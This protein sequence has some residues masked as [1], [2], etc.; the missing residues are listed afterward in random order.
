MKSKYL[1]SQP[2]ILG[3]D[4]SCDET[5]ASIVKG[6]RVLSNV[7]SSQVELHRKYGGVVPSIAKREHEERLE[8]VILEALSNAS[9]VLKNKISLKDIDAVAVTYG[10][11][12]AIALET[13]IRKAKEISKEYDKPLIAVN[14]MEGHLLSSLAENSK[15]KG[16]ISLSKIKFP[17]LGFLLSGGHTELILINDIGSYKVI[18]QTVDDAVGEAYD[19]V[20]RM[21]GLGYP[22]GKVLSEF[23]KKGDS[24][25][26]TLPVP[27]SKDPSLNLSFS[28]LKTAVYYM[29]KRIEEK[30]PLKKKEILDLSAGFERSAITS[31]KIKL[32]KAI[33]EYSPKMIFVGGG[34][35][36]SARVR[37][38]LRS[39]AKKHD[40][41][42][43][44]PFLKN[45]YTDNG[46]MIAVAGY[47]KYIDKTYSD[48]SLDR[49][50]NLSL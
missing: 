15:G 5:S 40:I 9:R 35:S 46:A 27:M 14:H 21:L 34:V 19:K 3:I 49:S 4:T 24:E 12:L 44:F 1:N 18:G 29:V 37:N 32:N 23:A 13:G 48:D 33:K 16:N 10:P 38:G 30:R 11:G 26:F 39:I 25:I 50:P 6:L 17:C 31:L 22:G 36:S 41:P 47:F 8:P 43:Y 7:I 2:L 45:L 20:A 42:I 28:G